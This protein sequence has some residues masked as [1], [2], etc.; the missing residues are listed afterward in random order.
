MILLVRPVMLDEGQSW[1]SGLEDRG[2]SKNSG[3][4]KKK[5]I[6]CARCA[7]ADSASGWTQ[8]LLEAIHPRWK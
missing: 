8:S 4:V 7:S 5:G 3:S 6:S 1:N 2:P